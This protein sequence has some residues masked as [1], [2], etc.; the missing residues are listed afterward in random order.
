MESVSGISNAR[1]TFI[2]REKENDPRFDA[3][4]DAYARQA[5]TR[6]AEAKGKLRETT[7]RTDTA[8]ISS[9]PKVPA[10]S[11]P[12]KRQRRGTAGTFVRGLFND[13]LPAA[14]QL[15]D[16][17]F[18]PL[19]GRQP[20]SSFCLRTF[21]PPSSSRVSLA[22]DF[23]ISADLL[24]IENFITGLSF[25]AIYLLRIYRIFCTGGRLL[26]ICF[27]LLIINDYS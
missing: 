6:S 17:R 9:L 20:R 16:P 13:T 15:T 2:C 1:G 14:F 24:F 22:G 21:P 10:E 8:N 18:R 4:F 26:Y 7:D 25:H 27:S 11:G 3:P 12:A 23:V 19:R 5:R